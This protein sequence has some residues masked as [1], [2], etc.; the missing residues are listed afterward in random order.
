MFA[1]CGC[2]RRWSSVDVLR[3]G[4]HDGGL[5]ISRAG[6]SRYSSSGHKSW[7]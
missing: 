7:W 3:V 2:R 6:V 5:G 1:S 4:V